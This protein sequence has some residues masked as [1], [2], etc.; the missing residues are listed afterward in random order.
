[1][2][3]YSWELPENEKKRILNLHESATKRFYLK[4]QRV[5]SF[6]FPV[7]SPLKQINIT[8]IYD[9]SEGMVL[10]LRGN[11]PEPIQMPSVSEIESNS[12][13]LDESKIQWIKNLNEIINLGGSNLFIPTYTK[14]PTSISLVWLEVAYQPSQERTKIGKLLHKNKT[15]GGMF[16]IVNTHPTGK[17]YPTTVSQN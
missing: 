16:K 17:E 2:K 3:E 15:K 14:K 12:S 1:M 11:D 5:G 13:I 9:L 7:V 8:A 10:S 4:E 6:N